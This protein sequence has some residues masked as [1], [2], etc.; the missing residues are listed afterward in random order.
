MNVTSNDV[1]RERVRAALLAIVASTRGFLNPNV[2]LDAARDPTHT[3]HPYFEWD[4]AVAG[5]SYRL[6][7]VGVLVRHVRLT[8]VR[9]NEETREIKVTTTRAYQ[10][11][12]SMRSRAGG[13]EGI[14]AILADADK[15]HELLAQVLR[16]L[17]SYRRR[18]AELS[19]LQPVWFAVD[20]AAADLNVSSASAPSADES[21]PGAAG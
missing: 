19:E 3:L 11:R 12:P 4:D 18:Y 9:E 10:S 2:V 20:E 13:Y 21:R 15:R 8:A 7:Q 16:E 14:A 17:A 5:E 1:E 6:A